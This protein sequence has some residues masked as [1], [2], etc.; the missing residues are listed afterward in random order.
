MLAPSYGT[1][2]LFSY[3]DNTFTYKIDSILTGLTPKSTCDYPCKTCTSAS[4]TTCLSC[5]P[6]VAQKYLHNS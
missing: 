2:T 5:F 3:T 4:R 6:N 1:F